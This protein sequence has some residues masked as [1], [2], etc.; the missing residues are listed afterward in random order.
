MHS[1]VV[2]THENFVRSLQSHHIIVPLNIFTYLLTY[3]Q[4]KIW[5][6]SYRISQLIVEVSV[7]YFASL[8]HTF[9]PRVLSTN[10]KHR[11]R[12]CTVLSIV[13]EHGFSA[14]LDIASHGCYCRKGLFKAKGQIV[15]IGDYVP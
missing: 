2:S 13:S 3:T 12:T 11:P 7:A 5:H 4:Y 15:R 10:R 1:S 9:M 6:Y 8:Q 14:V